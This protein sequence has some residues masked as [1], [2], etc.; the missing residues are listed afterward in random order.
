M[1]DTLAAGRA[2]LE[3]HGE[4]A[5]V[6]PH[7]DADGLSA[8]ALLAKVTHGGV[9]HVETPWEGSLDG[10]DAYVIVDWGVRPVASRVPSLYV[11]H[12]AD[13]ET[14][15]GVVVHA[16]QTG[17]RSTSLL[18]WRLLDGPEELV[19]L[20]A[21]GAVGDVGESA[22]R[23]AELA[24]AGSP[25]VLRRLA[26]LTSAPGRLRD[27]PVEIAFHVLAAAAT[28]EAALA[29]PRVRR[30]QQAR[31]AVDRLRRAA[32]RVPPEVGEAAALIRLDVPARVHSQVASAWTRRLAPRV[33]VAANAGW[34]PGRVSFSVRSAEPLDLRAWLRDIYEPPPGSGDY[35]RGHAR[36]TGGSL[37]PEAFEA[38]TVAALTARSP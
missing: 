30:L 17:D 24:T 33:V 18:A 8:G 5:V 28:A 3:A 23:Q 38:F 26:A 29:D 22:L 27:G 1:A 13:P 15:D 10:T 32:M 21:V 35:G 37:I 19:W 4:R 20:A 36:A 9:R 16:D 25:S 2:W 34:R 14:V 12:H 7:G 11:D 6:V 31:E